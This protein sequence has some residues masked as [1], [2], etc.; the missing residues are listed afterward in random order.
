MATNEPIRTLVISTQTDVTDQVQQI[1]AS[2]PSYRFQF[3]P[4]AERAMPRSWPKAG[5]ILSWL[6]MCL[7]MARR[8]WHACAPWP[9]AFPKCRL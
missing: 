8:P 7:P 4:S 2:E 9:I 6:T 3:T 1:F 5:W